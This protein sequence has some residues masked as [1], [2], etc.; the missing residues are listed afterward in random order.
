[1]ATKKIRGLLC[2][3]GEAVPSELR[4]DLT[5]LN[6]FAASDLDSLATLVLEHLKSAEIKALIS[7][8]SAFA[9]SRNMKSTS[10]LEAGVRG[11][12]AI[13]QACAMHGSSSADL[14]A[15]ARSLGLDAVRAAALGRSW[16]TF[17][18][19]KATDELAAVSDDDLRQLVD[20]EWKFGVTCA[21]S[22][23]DQPVGKTFLQLKLVLNRKN[24]GTY[25]NLY[26]ELSLPQF[27]DFLANMEKAKAAMKQIAKATVPSS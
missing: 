15:D 23:S 4:D 8:V 18:S 27:Y 9:K 20:I 6:A 5:S 12:I 24:D 1:M 25:E 19:P 10:V 7:A 26:L 14:E 22:E 13:L 16:D 17:A 21:S 11:L 2:F 3:G